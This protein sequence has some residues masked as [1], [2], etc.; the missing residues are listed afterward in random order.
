M[1]Q[2][3]PCL[4]HRMDLDLAIIRIMADLLCLHQIKMAQDLS[5]D[6]VNL[7]VMVLNKEDLKVQV[8]KEILK[9]LEVKVAQAVKVVKVVKVANREMVVRSLI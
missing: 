6:L 3:A 2:L 9:A 7:K 1:A 4:P 5:M 8:A